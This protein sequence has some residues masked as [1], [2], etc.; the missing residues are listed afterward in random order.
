[1]SVAD[2]RRKCGLRLDEAIGQSENL[3]SGVQENFR[4]GRPPCRKL[5]VIRWLRARSGRY[6]PRPS[7]WEIFRNGEPLPA[8]YAA[9]RLRI[10]AT[11]EGCQHPLPAG[12]GTPWA[13]SAAA[14][15][16]RLVTPAAWSDLTIGVSG[17]WSQRSGPLV[18][19]RLASYVSGLSRRRRE[20]YL[21]RF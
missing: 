12:G 13:F 16:F 9:K 7:G 17:A 19:R 5:S 20:T 21:L 14:N 11:C 15:A 6:D 10:S 4:Y 18:S 2:G 8:T 3:A 1:M